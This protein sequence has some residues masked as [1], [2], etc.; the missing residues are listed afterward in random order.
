MSWWAGIEAFI[1]ALIGAIGGSAAVAKFLGDWWFEKLKA[2]HSAEMAEIA[3]VR[4]I[5]LADRQNAFSMGT[6]SHMATVLFDKHIGFCEEYVEATSKALFTLIQAGRKDQPLDAKELS[7]IR[8]KWAL[9]L[10]DEIEANLDR[11]EQ[12]ITR[13]GGDAQVFDANGAPVS[14]DISIREP[15]IKLPTRI[16]CV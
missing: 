3:H 6:S 14:K 1:A 5:L 2:N 7:R 13:I 15:L 16:D 12:E 8:Q 10:N 9:W 11:F 4:S